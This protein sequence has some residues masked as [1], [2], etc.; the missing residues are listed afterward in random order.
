MLVGSGLSIT[1]AASTVV[2]DDLPKNIVVISDNAG[3]ISHSSVSI[4]DLQTISGGTLTP[5]KVVISDSNGKFST[6]AISTTE[7]GHLSG[8]NNPLQTQLDSKAPQVTT[9]SKNEV[10]FRLLFKQ[11]VLVTSPS[12]GAKV[13]DDSL[14]Q[15][16]NILGVDGISTSIFVDSA[17]PSNPQNNALIMSGAGISGGLDPNYITLA[18]GVITH[19]K[20]TTVGA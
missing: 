2:R 11:D 9:Y 19:H 7:V 15:V 14:K 6:S 1:G 13:W 16:R 5:N 17:N 3:K 10:D 12:I 8:V 20:D 18:N 4:D